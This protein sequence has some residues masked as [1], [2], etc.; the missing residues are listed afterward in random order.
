MESTEVAEEK[1]NDPATQLLFSGITKDGLQNNSEKVIEAVA[2]VLDIHPQGVSLDSMKETSNGGVLIDVRV[3]KDVEISKDFAEKIAKNL[4]KAPGFEHVDAIEP[5][6]NKVNP[7][8][9]QSS[10]ENDVMIRKIRRVESFKIENGGPIGKIFISNPV[11]VFEKDLSDASIK[12]FEDK[13]NYLY[14]HTRGINT[15]VDLKLYDTQLQEAAAK[16]DELIKTLADV[17]TVNPKDIKWILTQNGHNVDAKFIIANPDE[18]TKEICEKM[19]DE[20]V[21]FLRKI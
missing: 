19:P 12:N 10:D 16:R 18:N 11:Q 17:L 13:I 14:E 8:N 5:V 3:P 20:I 7:V 2:D 1:D 15:V 6:T 9:V 4:Q 21:E